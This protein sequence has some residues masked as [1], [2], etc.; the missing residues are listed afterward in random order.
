VTSALRPGSQFLLDSARKYFDK[1]FE[2]PPFRDD[3]HLNSLLRWNP[4]LRFEL[5]KHL[6]VL[7]EPSEEAVY[8][9]ILRLRYAHILGVH[10]PI[11]VYCSCPTEVC[12]AESQAD[13]LT[14]LVAHGMGL[15]SVDRNG[16][17]TRRLTAIPL[18]QNISDSEFRAHLGGLPPS[19]RQRLAE[20]FESYRSKPTSGVAEI[21]ELV[22]GVVHRAGKDAVGKA[23]LTK[24]DVKPGFSANTLDLL[25]AHTATKGQSAAWGAARGF[26][27]QWRNISHHFPANKKQAAKKYTE[28]RHA[29]LDGLK[30]MQALRTACKKVRLSGALP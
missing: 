26:V 4:G 5:N 22:E 27:A 13:D 25:I 21:T 16:I 20:A 23:W 9:Q 6:T 24:P 10:Q 1:V 8:P 30:Q 2:K 29:F 17:A 19:F 7:I 11:A 3:L 12:N 15:L 28:C 14:D 18:I